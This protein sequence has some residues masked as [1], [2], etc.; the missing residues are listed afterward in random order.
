MRL[1]MEMIRLVKGV[2]KILQNYM[3]LDPELV[4][5]SILNNERDSNRSVGAAHEESRKRITDLKKVSVAY[6]EYKEQCHLI[7]KLCETSD[8]F[9]EV[10]QDLQMREYMKRGLGKGS[11]RSSN[12][13]REV[14]R[15]MDRFVWFFK[16]LSLQPIN[17]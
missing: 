14:T 5:A 2:S 11:W 1:T 17:N 16:N 9:I 8:L 4:N 7:Q 10:N 12:Q 3:Q 15:I 13:L 6:G